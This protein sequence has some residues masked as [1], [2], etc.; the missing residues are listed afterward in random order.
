MIVTFG[1]NYLQFSHH[2]LSFQYL[3][4]SSLSSSFGI[5]IQLMTSSSDQEYLLEMVQKSVLGTPTEYDAYGVITEAFFLH[6]K[7][8]NRYTLFPQLYIPWKPSMPDPRGILP[9]FGIGRYYEQPPHIRLQGGVEVK[10]ATTFMIQLPPPG[11]V[12]RDE[13]VKIILHTSQF[14][15]ADQ[16]K[17]AVKGGLLPNTQLLWLM[18]IGPY[19]TTLEFGPFSAQQLITRS[20]K[21]NPS[22]D[23]SETLDIMMKK[24][25]DPI[26]YDLYLLGT[27]AAAEKLEFFINYTSKLLS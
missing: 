27:P 12:A 3:T 25:A 1:P 23:F 15:A 11:I 16:A 19:F 2:L 9:D 24:D 6:K 20:H 21:P 26:V 7:P 18:F 10:R 13:N 22:G 8:R 14:Q 5:L 4:L 17:A